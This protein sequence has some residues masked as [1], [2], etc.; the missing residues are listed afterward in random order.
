MAESCRW[1]SN[2]IISILLR[3]HSLMW[4]YPWNKTITFVWLSSLYNPFKN[5]VNFKCL[6]KTTCNFQTEKQLFQA[7]AK[8]A[9]WP[10]RFGIIYSVRT[11]NFPK[12]QHFLPTMAEYIL[13]IKKKIWPFWVNVAFSINFAHLLKEMPNTPISQNS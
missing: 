10:L 3:G 8:T 5:P 13:K 9:P 1:E 12:N 2:V 7:A 4:E 6:E 11:Q